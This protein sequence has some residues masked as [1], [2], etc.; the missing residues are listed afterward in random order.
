M[1]LSLLK[2]FSLVIFFT[3]FLISPNRLFSIFLKWHVLFSMEANTILKHNLFTPF[4]FGSLNCKKNLL[5]KAKL[6][7][8]GLNNWKLWEAHFSIFP[9]QP[10][11][12]NVDMKT[13]LLLTKWR[14]SHKS[15]WNSVANHPDFYII[16]QQCSYSS[17]TGNSLM[18]S[19][20]KNDSF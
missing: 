19:Y 1:E 3:T 17:Q 14:K 13:S 6:E 11:N 2:L 10:S 4:N 20:L 7:I 15:K 5:F 9:F 8:R 16:C 18:I 12:S